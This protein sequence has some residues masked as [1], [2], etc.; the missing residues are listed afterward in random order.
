MPVPVNRIS[1]PHAVLKA[2]HFN[3]WILILL[4]LLVVGNALTLC[5]QPQNII[6]KIT[7]AEGLPSDVITA[8]L[9]D[10]EGFIWIA[11][12]H[13]FCR[14]DGYSTLVFQHRETDSNSLID[15]AIPRN[16][17]VYDGNDKIMIGTSK[18]LSI[19][20]IKTHS[21]KNYLVEPGNSNALQSGINI[22][23][24]DGQKKLWAGTDKGIC[25][26]DPSSEQFET[27]IFNEEIPSGV[28]LD[29]ND[30]NRIH[31]IQ[32]DPNDTS[33]LWLASLSGLLKF[34][35]ATGHFT[36]YYYP[37]QQY[38]REINQFNM[39]VAHPDGNLILGTWN[40]DL[41]VFNTADDKFTGRF[42]PGA[43]GKNF[44]NEKITPY[45]L[46]KQNKIWVSSLAG[47]GIFDPEKQ[48]FD[49]LQSFENKS[50][51]RQQVELFLQDKNDYLWLG[52]ETGVYLLRGQNSPIENHFFEATDENH[53]Y[54]TRQIVED[55][56]NDCLIIA[57]G[58]GDGLHFYDLKT[59]KFTSLP[60]PQ[61]GI[62]EF[63]ISALILEPSGDLLFSTSSQIFRYSEIL[64]Q[65]NCISKPFSKFPIINDMK[66]DTAGNIWLATTN[67]GLMKF[68]PKTGYAESIKA[69]QDIIE[70]ENS[71]PMIGRISIDPYG[72]IWFNRRNQSY[73]FYD[74]S[75]DKLNYFDQPDQILNITAFGDYSGDTLWIATA[76]MG[77][78]F[79]NTK[80]PEKG[81]QVLIRKEKM[82]RAYI[83]D[84][85]TD[86]KNRLWC[87]TGIGLLIVDLSNL[88]VDLIDENNGLIV[89]DEWSDKNALSPGKLLLLNKGQLAIGYRRG[90]GFLD[91][92]NLDTP[93]V[94]PAPYITS[95]RVMDHQVDQTKV[96]DLSY[97]ENY[98][99]LT[100]SAHDLYH[101]GFVLRHKL[102]GVDQ[103]WQMS[104]AG[105]EVIYPNLSAGLYRFVV[106]TSTATGLDHP[107]EIALNFRINPP[108][109]KTSRAI[110][111]L[112]IFG[113]SG[114]VLLYRYQLKRQ[115]ALQE[116]QRLR[117][118]DDLKTRL[119]TN[120][121]HEFR[122]PITVIMGIAADLAGKA[123]NAGEFQNKL[124]TISR[125]S[126]N[127]LHLVNQLLDLAKLEHGKLIYAPICGNIISWMQYLVESHQSLAESKNIRLT[128]Y[129]EIPALDMDYDPDQLSKVISNLLTNAIKFTP[130]KGKV[131]FH[132]KLDT[133]QNKLVFKVR[134]DGI[135]IPDQEQNRIFDRFYQVKNEDR[136]FHGGTG[137]GLSL[138][139]EIV[140]LAGGTISVNSEPEKGS[141]FIVCLPITSNAPQK[142]HSNKNLAKP[143]RPGI[144]ASSEISETEASLSDP[145]DKPLVL[146]AEDNADVA[147]FIRD[148]I[149]LH[150]KVKWAADGE[151]AQEMAMNLIP[152]LVIMD[153]MMPGKNGFEVCDILKKDIR[154]DHIPVI[155]LT[156]RVADTDRISGYERGADAYLT[157]PF[158]QKELLVRME[159]LLKLRRQLQA[160]YGKI[161]IPSNKDTVQTPEEQFLAK[162]ILI[163]E[164]NLD[165][166]MFNASELAAAIHL[167]ESQLYRKLKAITGKST[168]IFIRSVRLKN[169]KDLLES[170]N[171]SVSEVAYMVGFND[172]AWFS[173]VF[174]EEF[175]MAPSEI[176]KA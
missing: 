22:V 65:I 104:Q 135:G 9:K 16:G 85:V 92:E 41:V 89:K 84:I 113:I 170:S 37:D 73:G 161:D 67:N 59:K 111:V 144:L 95:L 140:E 165:K 168:A 78:G 17:F 52:S 57:Y 154:T 45:S 31:A 107:K 94:L 101:Q 24:I 27:F 51:H 172:P 159:Q 7:V 46:A 87:L 43:S 158:N 163:V 4:V 69:F 74:P 96:Q 77:L 88:K 121:T 40:F 82:P 26:Y 124:E 1:K 164:N 127:L 131:I 75:A 174:K 106:Q 93:V 128:F 117:E 64:G 63:N 141:E 129:S 137:I 162:A 55:T 112:I 130:S 115:L 98:I 15:D 109:W 114:I 147:G 28:L 49:F 160:K 143:P 148:T 173:R 18:G 102:E 146:I 66:A 90:L 30:I 14:W 134:D 83:T 167:S 25:S 44:L 20:D 11:T 39:M 80:K 142:Q 19:F 29:R 136:Q 68:D 61:N 123:Y 155:M 35:K 125:N 8:I 32:E 21:F 132:T 150:Y 71:L 149:R 79:V 152:D 10:N 38:L 60:F 81:Y 157:K 175:G 108:W 86:K 97:D 176:L 48:S 103:N 153:V 12:D 34:E 72:K 126:D 151:K 139:K 76:D 5:A 118:L 122:T 120:I 13:G 62:T 105:K 58:R 100:Y 54:L 145:K 133:V 33:V 42:G 156:A 110:I 171:L 119:Y 99:A 36:W 169:A 50:G 53:W 23:F 47:L 56:K 91:P 2:L 70:Q 6:R 116:A 166:S 138:T 3:R